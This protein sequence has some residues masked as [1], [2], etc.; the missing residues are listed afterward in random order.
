M[1]NVFSGKKRGQNCAYL[2]L[3]EIVAGRSKAGC[4]TE[5]ANGVDKEKRSLEEKRGNSGWSN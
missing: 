1:G 3:K 2:K 4:I 5:K